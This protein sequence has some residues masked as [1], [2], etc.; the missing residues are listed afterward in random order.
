MKVLANDG[1]DSIGKKLLEDEGVTVITDKIK[2]E[3]LINYL[4]D[5]TFDGIVVRSAT[6]VKSDIIKAC[7]SLK[8]IGRAG[9]GLDNIDVAAAQEQG[10]VVVNT[11]DSSSQSVAELVF[12]HFYSLSRFLHASHIEMPLN[13]ASRFNDLKKAYSAGVELKGKTLGV[14][15]FGRI[16]QAV[17]KI[18]IGS[19]MKI[20]AYDPFL[21]AAEL[22]LDFY[23]IGK[24]KVEINTCSFNDLITTSDFI[25][26]HVPHKEGSPALIGADNLAKMKKGVILVNASRGGVVDE[27]ALFEA[28]ESGQVAGAGLDVF[29]NEPTP[30]ESLLKHPKV[31]ATPHIGASTAEAQERIGVEMAKKLIDFFQKNKRY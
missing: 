6:K 2:Q 19:G 29:V 20:K 18:G 24:I 22:D 4:N 8:V 28:L 14:I 13:G 21:Q 25:T 5:G 3:D 23:S 12:A 16:G 27:V 15:G 7:P 10:I 1:I 9:V 17:A 30:S 11:P 31:S 26:L